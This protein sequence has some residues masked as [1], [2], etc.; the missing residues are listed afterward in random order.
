MLQSAD[1]LDPSPEVVKPLLHSVHGAALVTSLKKPRLQA[2]HFACPT[3][4]FPGGQLTETIEKQDATDVKQ[5][6]FSFFKLVIQLI[7]CFFF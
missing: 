5:P 3:S 4:S 7:N 2:T 6:F 1:C